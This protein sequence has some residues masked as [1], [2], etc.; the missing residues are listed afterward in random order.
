MV[1]SVRVVMAG[2]K[3]IIP[4]LVIIQSLL[5]HINIDHILIFNNL[6]LYHYKILSKIFEN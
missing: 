6:T 1:G 2:M 5:V 4:Y 3:V